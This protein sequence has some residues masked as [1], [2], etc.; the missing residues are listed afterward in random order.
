MHVWIAR[1]SLRT[2][3]YAS[4]HGLASHPLHTSSIR[5]RRK[6]PALPCPCLGPATPSSKTR[7][8]SRCTSPSRSCRCCDRRL[9]AWLCLTTMSGRWD[10]GSCFVVAMLLPTQPRTDCSSHSVR[11]VLSTPLSV[12]SCVCLRCVAMLLMSPG[13]C[14]VVVSSDVVV[15]RAGSGVG[16]HCRH[17]HRESE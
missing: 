10:E 8:C 1:V 9:F 13:R 12:T 14:A 4:R 3:S 5:S 15:G 6:H 17:C 2:R 11:V 16:R 7:V